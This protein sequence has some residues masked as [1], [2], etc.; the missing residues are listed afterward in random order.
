[1]VIAAELLAAATPATGLAAT[2]GATPQVMPTVYE[3]GHFNAVP[4]TRDGQRL[5]LV[6][7]T[8]GGG[9]G[10]CWISGAAANR[11]HRKPVIAPR[12][13]AI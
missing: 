5:K 1:M 13:A 10:L 11:L 6:V 2:T 4:E 8:G 3:V 7:D 9:D 12:V